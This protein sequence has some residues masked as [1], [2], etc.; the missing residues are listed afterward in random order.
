MAVK[1]TTISLVSTALDPTGFTIELIP[2]EFAIRWTKSSA[3]T[4]LNGFAV[5]ALVKVTTDNSPSLEGIGRVTALTSTASEA[6]VTISF[7]SEW[8]YD[9]VSAQITNDANGNWLPE[10][11]VSV[12]S[13]EEWTLYYLIDSNGQKRTSAHISYAMTEGGQRYEYSVKGEKDGAIPPGAAILSDDFSGQDILVV[14]NDG[15]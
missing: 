11:V 5:R 1:T 6:S 9:S 13:T 3:D 2:D 15:L 14:Y 12:P 4:I 8:Q 7:P 10:D